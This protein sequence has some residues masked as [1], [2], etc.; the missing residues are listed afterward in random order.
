MIVCCICNSTFKNF[1]SLGKHLYYSHNKIE[2]EEYYTQYINE[3]SN[4][5][6]CGSIKKFRNLGEGYR[7]YCSPKCRSEN[8]E[9]A[10]PWLGKKQT[11]EHIHKRI[12]NTNQKDKEIVRKNT[13]IFRYGFDN[14]SLLDDIKIKISKSNK[15]RKTPRVGNQQRNIIE[16]RIKNGTLKHSIET[17]NKIRNSL[18]ILYSSDNP[19]VTISENN[20]KNHKSGYFKGLYYR[21]SY[22][23]QF[24]EYC[25]ENNIEYISA[26]NKTFRLPYFIGEIRKWYYPD[27]Y[28]EKY[29]AVI[30]IKPN[31][32]LTN[33]VVMSKINVGMQNYRFFVIDEE[34][35]LDLDNFFE[36]LENE[37]LYSVERPSGSSTTSL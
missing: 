4:I 29:D 27:F 37:Y 1:N 11:Q 12:Q 28:L 8:V 10:K 32:M 6:V 20:N 33:D 21:S 15:G 14:P 16:S 5:C 7:L 3:V 23:L 36:E 22:E 26:E 31:S 35:L 34:V 18:I 24:M 9:H 2:K 13:M 30:E 25:S 17:R 19:P